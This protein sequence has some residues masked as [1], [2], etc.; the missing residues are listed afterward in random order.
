M[1]RADGVGRLTTH[2]S[3]L[4]THYPRL[5]SHISHLTTH[6]LRSYALTVFFLLFLASATLTAQTVKLDYNDEKNKETV[7][8]QLFDS[9]NGDFLMELPLTFHV[10]EDYVLFVIIG[11]ETGIKKNTAICLFDETMELNDLTK[12]NRNFTFSDNFKKYH[13]KIY[14]FFERTNNVEMMMP[15]QNHCEYIETTPKP[16]FFQIKNKANS[17]DLKL[18]FYLADISNK[19]KSG[20]KLIAESGT[21]KT[22]INIIK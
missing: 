5:T 13:K 15:F 17:I 21:I 14:P 1:A 7:R 18:R 20:L 4:T 11:D 9:Y 10:T 19:E 22:T 6:L 16:L 12:K 3:L 2:Y 8:V